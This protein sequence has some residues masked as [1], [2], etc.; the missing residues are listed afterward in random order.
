VSN[1]EI[2]RITSDNVFRLFSKMPRPS[3]EV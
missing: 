3:E 2:A 1:D